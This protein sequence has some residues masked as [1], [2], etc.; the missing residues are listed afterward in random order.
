MITAIIPVRKGSQRVKNKNK[1][2][3]ANSSLLEIKIKQL[4]EL[5]KRNKIAEIIVSSD[6]Q[7]MLDIA[8]KLG[9]IAHNRTEYY[10]SSKAT[11]S[12]FF[13]N[14][15]KTVGKEH[16]IMYSPVTSPLIS[17]KT[18]NEILKTLVT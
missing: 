18:Y 9:A 13:E 5:Q 8:K 16:W 15:A 4:L 12:E 1:K 17:I 6:D 10:A 14:L 11:N 7:E 3:F 2:K